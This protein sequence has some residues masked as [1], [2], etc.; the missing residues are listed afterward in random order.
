MSPSE[1]LVE[2]V[3]PL[4]GMLL[5]F[6]MVIAIIVVVT[7]SR[8]RRMEMQYELQSKLIEKFGSTGEL[9]SFLQSE[10]GQRFVNSVQSGTTKLAR[11]KA[12]SAVRIGIVFT[13]LGAAFLA[14]WAIMNI[15]GLAW[16]GVLFTMLGVAYFASSYATMRFSQIR[17]AEP[18]VLPASTNE[19]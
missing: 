11:D 6:A 19:G 7:R 15:R 14:L 17:P 12:A 4:L 18:P 2:G 5:S 10:T 8:Q 1:I 16:P 3:L 13:A 9:I